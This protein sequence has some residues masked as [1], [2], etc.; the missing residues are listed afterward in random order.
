MV[1]G[2]S[3]WFQVVPDGSRWFQMVPGGSRWF[4]M[5]LCRWFYVDGSMQMVPDGSRWFQMVLCR[6]FY[7]GGSMQMVPDGSRQFHVVPPIHSQ[8]VKCSQKGKLTLA[9]S[10]LIN[11]Q[12]PIPVQRRKRLLICYLHIRIIEDPIPK[13]RYR[14]LCLIYRL[15]Y[16]AML[17]TVFGSRR[18]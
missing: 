7:L 15:Y 14:L 6:W 1:P 2:G 4:Q 12:S 16:I 9:K 8:S 18:I 13:S 11:N 3:T 10:D 17:Q 5:V